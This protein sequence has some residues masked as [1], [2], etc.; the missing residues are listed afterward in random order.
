M[1]IKNYAILRSITEIKH[2]LLEIEESI[3]SQKSLYLKIEK[4]IALLEKELINMETEKY[5]EPDS[6]QNLRQ[7]E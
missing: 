7:T 5:V 6:L 1:V 2:K 4:H 3:E